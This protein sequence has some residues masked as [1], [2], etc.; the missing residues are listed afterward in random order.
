MV[1]YAQ[2]PDRA[3]WLAARD[4]ER[5]PAAQAASAA[6]RACL[7]SSRTAHELEV[8]SDY[9]QPAPHPVGAT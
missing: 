7:K 1:A 9:L 5:A 3:T 4:V 8:T 2:W 6:M